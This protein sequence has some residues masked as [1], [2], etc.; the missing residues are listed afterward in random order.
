MMIMRSEQD[1]L[2]ELQIASDSEPPTMRLR[3]A[4]AYYATSMV[5]QAVVLYLCF[6]KEAVSLGVFFATW[7]LQGAWLNRKVLRRLITWHPVYS[8]VSNVTGAKLRFW[9]LWPIHYGILLVQLTLD[10]LI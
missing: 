6:Y 10:R 9:L 7:L 3:V 1:V 8:T 2:E 5:V 4:W